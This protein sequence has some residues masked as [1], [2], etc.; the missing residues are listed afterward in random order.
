MSGVA[1]DGDMHGPL[2]SWCAVALVHADRMNESFSDF[3]Q[4]VAEHQFYVQRV[5]AGRPEEWEETALGYTHRL[6]FGRM[7]RLTADIQAFIKRSGADREMRPDHRRGR[8]PRPTPG[9]LHSRR[10]QPR[11]TLGRSLRLHDQ[12]GE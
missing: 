5:E 8:I 6:T 12:A 1:F 10:A 3:M 9:S 4:A 2:Y 11:G 7:W